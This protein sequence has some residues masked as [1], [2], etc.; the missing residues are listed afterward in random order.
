MEKL[1]FSTGMEE[2][3]LENGSVLRFNPRDPSVLERYLTLEERINALKPQGESVAEKWADAD[4]RCRE[5]LEEVFPGNDFWQILGP[6]N[7]LALC[8]NGMS[9]MGNFLNAV[10]EI[11]EYGVQVLMEEAIQK[12]KERRGE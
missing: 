12:A 11:L 10:E 5:M 2:Y 4:M 6:G 3:P 7:S 8:E 1:V 9:V